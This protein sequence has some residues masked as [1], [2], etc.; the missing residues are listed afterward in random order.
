MGDTEQADAAMVAATPPVLLCV[1]SRPEITRR[2]LEVLKRARVSELY[3]A[4]DGPRAGNPLDA[5]RCGRVRALIDAVDWPVNVHRLF[6]DSNVGLDEAM[7]SSIDWFFTHVEAGIV[8]EDDCVPVVEWFR[9]AR[10]ILDRFAGV[11]RVMQVS[12]LN[13]ADG[14]RYTTHS[15]FFA[16]VGHIWGW[17]TWRR[18]WTLYDRALDDWPLIRE[19]VARDATPLRRMLARKFDSAHAGRKAS[20]T[21]SWYFTQIRFGGLAVIPSVNLVENI[22]V[23]D[24]ATHPRRRRHPLRRPATRRMAFPLDHPEDAMPN[25]RYERHL[26]RYHARSYAQRA[27][28]RV[29]ILRDALGFRRRS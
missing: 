20:W 7:V 11:P 9:F 26:A 13:M 3:V 1:F 6:R 17:A 18:A 29:L 10:E 2:Q 12:A 21:R 28:E 27:R 23:G 16:E 8:L 19:E 22:G 15:Y 24:D 14:E 5:E 25:A 4:A